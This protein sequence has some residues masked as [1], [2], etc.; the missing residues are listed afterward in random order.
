MYHMHAVCSGQNGASDPLELSRGGLEG[1]GVVCKSTQSSQSP[2]CLQF[3][4]YFETGPHVAQANQLQSCW[5]V[6]A[7]FELL[8][9]SN[10]PAS[11]HSECLEYRCKPAHLAPDS[12][13]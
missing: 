4:F 8:I 1:A 10:P 13:F 5:V 11:Q 3:C 12:L 2:S 9:H 7:D 6:K